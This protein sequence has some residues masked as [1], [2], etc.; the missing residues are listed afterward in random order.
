MT[1]Q[2][3]DQSQQRAMLQTV[4]QTMTGAQIWGRRVMLAV[5]SLV[6]A[7]P[8]V[9]MRR[10]MT[11][12]IP[13]GLQHDEINFAYVIGMFFSVLLVLVW[14]YAYVGRGKARIM[15]GIVYLLTTSVTVVVPSA[16]L[17]M[18]TALPPS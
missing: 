4:P 12:G 13:T 8:V 15:L 11:E 9:D 6:P 5:L 3:Q 10:L 18:G 14:Y 1:E 2:D 16:L 7:I 17:F